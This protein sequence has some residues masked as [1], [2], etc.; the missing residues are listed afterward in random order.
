V[1]DIRYPPNPQVETSGVNGTVSA[2]NA[3]E[4]AAHRAISAQ[5]FVAGGVMGWYGG[6]VGWQ[7]YLGLSNA[8]TAY[9]K[10]LATTKV[11]ARKY[12]VH[13]RLWRQPVWRVPAAEVPTMQLHD[14]S[15]FADGWNQ[16]CPTSLVLAECWQADDGTFAIVATNH[17]ETDITLN[18]SVD[19]SDVGAAA[20][21]FVHVEKPMAGR[22]VDVI[23]INQ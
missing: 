6:S 11:D 14:Y 7:N 17:G 19:L 10:L 5:N 21:V 4:A 23:V 2:F 18:V 8:D 12:L 13:G 3:T 1:G 20:P 15:V 16:S 22:S 9:T